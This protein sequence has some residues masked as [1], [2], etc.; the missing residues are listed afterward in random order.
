M[1]LTTSLVLALLVA[2][3]LSAQQYDEN[4]DILGAIGGPAAP[5]NV[6]QTIVGL[7]ARYNDLAH[8]GQ[9]LMALDGTTAVVQLLNDATGASAGS[10][11]ISNSSDYGLAWDDKRQYVVTT[12]AS[13]DVVYVY[14][15]TGVLV[16]SWP[17]PSTGYVGAAWD[18]RRDVYW[19]LDW[20]VNTVTAIN[21]STG[22]LGT[23]HSTSAIGCTRGAGLG[24]DANTDT[25][26]FGGRDQI[27]MFGMN[28]ATGA[29]V[30]SFLG[31]QGSSNNPHGVAISPR[32]G[33][34]ESIY[35]SGALNEYEGCT[36][37]HPELRFS[38]NFPTAGFPV[39]LTMRYLAPGERA[40][41]VYS[42]T[43][44]GPTASPIGDLLLSN[45]RSVLAIV[46]AAGGTATISGNVPL[47]LAGTTVF[48]HGGG[49]GGSGRCNNVIIKP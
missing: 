26:Y 22:A 38:P 3:P 31:D 23:V 1:K 21:P 35:Q 13:T 2:G 34:W 25:L 12:N 29:L 39:T 4:G 27:T 46:P 14:T 43:G 32:G 40:I 11:P 37:T 28:A 15:R 16:T 30:C 36:P 10:I 41:F 49:L 18:C 19:V 44:C 42:R 24:Y 17:F 9:Y 33:I 5:G 20:T 8:D 6:L 48:F 7:S 45:P 47:G